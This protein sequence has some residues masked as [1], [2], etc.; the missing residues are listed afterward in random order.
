MRSQASPLSTIVVLAVMGIFIIGS[1]A[2]LLSSRPKPVSITINPPI[3]TATPA[4]TATPSPILVYVTGAVMQPQTTVQIPYDSRVA[5]AIAAVGGLSNTADRTRVNLAGT[6]R[7]GD[8]VH[9]P[10]IVLDNT[11]TVPNALPTSSSGNMVRINTATQEELESLP[12]I[13]PVTAQ[14]IIA[15]RDANGAY[16][17]LEDLDNVSGIGPATLEQLADLILFD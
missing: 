5:D 2:L 10:E 14:N 4:P 8:Q 13:G 11:Q 16:T 1:G 12:G 17:Q 9:V 15:Y 7:D 6:L 3:P